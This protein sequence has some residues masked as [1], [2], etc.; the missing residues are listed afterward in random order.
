MKEFFSQFNKKRFLSVF[1]L[2]LIFGGLTLSAQLVN[3]A[4]SRFQTTALSS[5]QASVAFYVVDV[6]TTEN[7]IALT[8]LL[9]SSTPYVYNFQVL[10]Y[11]VSG[12]TKVNLDYD[13]KFTTTTNLPLTFQ[14]FRNEEYG[15]GATNIIDS[16][17]FWQDANN[18]Y[19]HDL[20]DETSYS[21]PYDVNTVDN[22]VLVVNFPEQYKNQPDTYQ[23]WIDLFT[24]TVNARQK[25]S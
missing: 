11:D 19:Y 4:Y 3:V 6:G 10:N 18:V 15:S 16:D 5:A 24:I 23:G 17:E 9:P 25:V 2:I 13:I 12:R 20:V 1:R 8:G 22:Y 7:T 14:V 21:L